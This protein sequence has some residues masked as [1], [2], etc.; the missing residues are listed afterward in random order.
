M[1]PRPQAKGRQERFFGTVQNRLVKGMRKAGVCTLAAAN[2]KGLHRG[3]GGG[4]FHFI[5]CSR[6][7]RQPFVGSARRRRY[8]SLNTLDEV[9][10]A[11]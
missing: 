9:K 1:D 6:H 4:E 2:Q 3:Y 10:K 7:R 5:T 8:P 11:V